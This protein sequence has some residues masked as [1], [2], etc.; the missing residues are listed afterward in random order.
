[1]WLSTTYQV[2]ARVRQYSRVALHAADGPTIV[3]VPVGTYQGGV[4]ADGRSPASAM[5]S[6]A[7]RVG[8]SYGV[9]NLNLNLKVNGDGGTAVCGTCFY[10]ALCC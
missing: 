1:M 4:C 2:A 9:L 10:D 6:N 3:E 8:R 7:I 5:R